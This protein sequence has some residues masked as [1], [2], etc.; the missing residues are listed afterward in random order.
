MRLLQR[1]IVEVRRSDDAR[2]APT[3]D[4]ATSRPCGSCSTLTLIA[5]LR[6]I[7]DNGG[8][9]LCATHSPILA[10][11]PGAQILEI[12]PDG[13]RPTTWEDLELVRHWKSYLDAPGR[14]LRHL[15]E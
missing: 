11:L 6:R 2:I 3:S 10:A 8:Q 1:P 7:A 15:L 12:G 4:R 9:I 14:Y 5:T 13:I